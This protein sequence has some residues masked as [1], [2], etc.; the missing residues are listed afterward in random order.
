MAGLLVLATALLV[1]SASAQTG[2]VGSDGCRCIGKPPEWMTGNPW[3][4]DLSDCPASWGA[5]QK[6]L[7]AVNL[8]RPLEPLYPQSYGEL[9]QKHLEPAQAACFDLAAGVEKPSGQQ[10][11]WCGQPWCYVDPCNCNL[12]NVQPAY[13]WNVSLH[14]SY[15]TCGGSDT[16]SVG[17]SFNCDV[18]ELDSAGALSTAFGVAVAGLVAALAL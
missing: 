14:Y 3:T 10:A 8:S 16:Y 6:C 11:A 17:P 13:Y 15:E 2:G 4:G 12:D 18:P 1:G 7:R 9:C 5:G